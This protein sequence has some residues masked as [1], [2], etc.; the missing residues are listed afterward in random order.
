MP[1]KE[2]S[3]RPRAWLLS[4]L[5]AALAAVFLGLPTGLTALMVLE[6]RDT[7]FWFVAFPAIVG[8]VVLAALRYGRARP[9]ATRSARRRSERKPVDKGLYH[10]GL[11]A[12]FKGK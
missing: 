11:R 8:A 12:H 6:S 2:M 1:T 3:P 5:I 10:V 4:L 7:T 9:P